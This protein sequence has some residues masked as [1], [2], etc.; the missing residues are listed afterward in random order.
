MTRVT[1]CPQI[2]ISRLLAYER[3]DPTFFQI[4]T[5]AFVIL[6]VCWALLRSLQTA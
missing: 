1:C 3:L 2:V 4:I 5:R 6:H